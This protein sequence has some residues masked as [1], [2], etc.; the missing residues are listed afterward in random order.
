VL[1]SERAKE[2][3]WGSLGRADLSE[4]RACPGATPARFKLSAIRARSQRALGRRTVGSSP[5]QRSQDVRCGPG[6]PPSR[7]ENGHALLGKGMQT[8]RS[9]WQKWEARSG[10]Q[11]ADGAGA[12]SW[13]VGEPDDS[14][15]GRRAAHFPRPMDANL[16][17]TWRGFA[18]A[19]PFHWRGFR[20]GQG[21]QL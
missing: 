7:A 2:H 15:H 5:L 4:E 19:V 20:S 1:E 10:P 13:L 12:L 8:R 6:A 9:G 11:R 16:T 14:S 3:M 18:V 21:R 17:L